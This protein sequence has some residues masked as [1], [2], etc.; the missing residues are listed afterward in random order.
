[1]AY[2]GR[3]DPLAHGE[4]LVLV[5]DECKNRDHYQGLDKEYVFRVLVGVETDTYD[6][7]GIITKTDI[8]ESFKK[9]ECIKLKFKEFVGKYFQQYPIYSSKAV[10]GKPMFWWAKSGRLDEIEIPEKGV[11]IY[12]L[13]LINEEEIKIETLVKYINSNIKKVDGD[14]RQ[15]EII[16]QWSDLLVNNP[17]VSFKVLKFKA[18]VSSGSYVRTLARDLGRACNTTALALEI[19]RTMIK[20]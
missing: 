11:S 1:M 18:A 12:S 7:M 10:D 14:F 6:P 3:L 5:G 8:N 15:D 13:D 2:A 19:E 16:K 4:L 20:V 9:A 17:N